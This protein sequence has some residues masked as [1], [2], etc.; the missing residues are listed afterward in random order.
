MCM[1]VLPECMSVHHMCAVSPEARHG[2]QILWNWS[3][4]SCELSCGCYELNLGS[5]VEQ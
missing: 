4:T 5:V 2:F 1:D 3:Y